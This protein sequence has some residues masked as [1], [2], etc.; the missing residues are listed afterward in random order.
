[1]P[2][3]TKGK[4]VLEEAYFLVQNVS[5]S[6]L[7]I[8]RFR[9]LIAIWFAVAYVEVL[10]E[11][12]SAT[13]NYATYPR[14][15]FTPTRPAEPS[16]PSS[17]PKSP[18]AVRRQSSS[19]LEGSDRLS[20]G[21]EVVNEF[22]TQISSSPTSH[23]RKS[24]RPSLSVE[25]LLIPP[26]TSA[27]QESLPTASKAPERCRVLYNYRKV[28]EDEMDLREGEVVEVIER[29]DDGWFQGKKKTGETGFAPSNY[30]QE[31]V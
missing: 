22:K 13:A 9:V 10:K 31:I 28:N 5:L 6:N 19:V 21:E 14:N 7:S 1:M 16:V 12:G 3:G 23:L 26:P 30:V 17:A 24:S 20:G 27:R 8:L 4:S 29:C 11:P 2:I 25:E 15:S 18:A